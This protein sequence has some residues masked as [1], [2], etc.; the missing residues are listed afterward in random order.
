M[1]QRAREDVE[2]G[3]TRGQ[4]VCPKWFKKGG[5]LI[6]VIVAVVVFG[7]AGF[8]ELQRS[9]ARAVVSN[10][11]STME[12]RSSTCLSSFHVGKTDFKFV[13]L[14]GASPGTYD[15]MLNPVPFQMYG[16]KVKT[17]ETA[18]PPMQCARGAQQAYP[19]K[20]IRYSNITI[21]HMPVDLEDRL[22]PLWSML[23]KNYK[24]RTF[25]GASRARPAARAAS[26]A[27]RRWRAGTDS[28]CLQ[29]MVEFLG[30]A[31]PC[32]EL[33]DGDERREEL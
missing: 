11:I 21:S 14:R 13:V 16:K 5:F 31:N 20:R 26:E 3:R 27:L 32:A 6:F 24:Q 33:P 25:G 23:P 15:V 22:W 19:I 8:C 18:H 29:H 4:L 7:G 9:D 2:S 28:L 12:D 17:E 10:I 30:Q 1:Q